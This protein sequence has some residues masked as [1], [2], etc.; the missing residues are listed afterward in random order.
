M[1]REYDLII[2][3]AGSAGLVAAATAVGMG[4]SVLLVENR[5]MGGDCLNYGCVPSKTFLSSSH[6][7][8]ELK[9]GE[10][11][12][13]KF[14]SV[15]VSL[16]AVM[17]RVASVI[18]EIAPHDSKERFEKLGVDVEFGKGVI[19]S[20]TSVKVHDEIF[21][22]KKILIA[23]G[24][25]AFVPSIQGLEG[26]AYYTNETIFSL[27]ELPKKMIV[28]GAGPI[29]L[30]L[31]Q[32][33]AHLGSEV[34]VIDRSKK[35][36]KKDA[37]EVS[38]IMTKV[39]SEELN[40]HMNSEILGVAKGED[41]IVVTIKEE[42]KITAV[43]GDVLL[44]ALGRVPNTNGIGLEEVGVKQDKRGFIVT[45]E[46]LRSS[47]KTIY[48]CG[49]VIGG[50]LFT[51]AAS[52]EASV[53]V[54]NALI[55]PIFNRS[56]RNMAWTTYTLPE[57]AHVGMM[58]REAKE[59]GIFGVAYQLKIDENDRA[60]AEEDRVGYIKVVLDKK[61]RVIGGTIVGKKAGEML[62][63]LSLM[64]VKKMALTEALGIIYQYPIQ[65]EI[66]KSLAIQD[67]KKSVKPWQLSLMKKIVRR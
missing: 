42:G 11:K 14:S 57:V 64:I 13:V 27:S 54:K 12:G 17:E 34:H 66:I 16:K 28:L 52:Y 58:E 30:E 10:S 39:L 4:A 5:K 36:F 55:A 19:I 51:H 2:L 43:S 44:I 7:V 53:A 22:S 21:Q 61:K 15:E 31:G 47:V 32:G 33:F 23:T 6:L 49:D 3:G 40:L 63:V 18:A 25:S 48:A 45:D 8:K 26:I 41:E 67:F 46:K 9:E 37:E 56:Y 60:K 38:E 62:P 59:K 20:S 24:S 1:K 65:G 29:G 35:L 50:Y